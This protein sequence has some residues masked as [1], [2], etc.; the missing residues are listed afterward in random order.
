MRKGREGKMDICGHKT[1]KCLDQHGSSIR[2]VLKQAHS[3][4]LIW[5]RCGKLA[6]FNKYWIDR[7]IS[8]WRGRF[9]QQ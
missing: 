5:K 9:E 6:T 7:S 1:L 4:F 2:P 3:W 8:G